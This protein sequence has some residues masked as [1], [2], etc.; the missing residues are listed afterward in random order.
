MN[1]PTHAHAEPV[2][3]PTAAPRQAAPS[4]AAA[5]GWRRALGNSVVAAL[6]EASGPAEQAADAAANRV[7]GTRWAAAAHRPPPPPSPPLVSREAGRPLDDATRARFEAAFAA[8]L[9]GVRLHTDAAAHRAA[10]QLGAAAFAAG[11][12]IAFARGTYAPETLRGAWLLAHEIAH[13]LQHDPSAPELVRC[14][15]EDVPMLDGRLYEG[16]QKNSTE[17][18]RQA[19]EA[20]NAFSE[21]DIRL[22]LSPAPGPGRRVLSRGQIAAIHV[23]AREHPRLGP[24]SNAATFTRPAYLDVNLDN[25][26]TRG[27]WSGAAEYLNA[28]ND[29]DMKARLSTF[30]LD[31]LR[32]LQ[33]GAHQ[34]AK[35]GSGSAAARNVAAAIAEAT[36]ALAT[37]G[38]V[39]LPTSAHGAGPPGSVTTIPVGRDAGG[40]VDVRAADR[41]PLP[42]DRD[43]PT[44]PAFIDRNIVRATYGLYTGLFQIEYA[45]G[46]LLSLD[47][48]QVAAGARAGAPPVPG[49][50]RHRR[51]G[52]IYPTR[53]TRHTVPTI[54]AC[55]ED[56]RRREPEALR[57]A[58]AAWIDLAVSAHGVAGAVIRTGRAQQ[59]TPATRETAPAERS[60]GDG[61]ASAPPP[62]RPASPRGPAPAAGDGVSVAGGATRPTPPQ[63]RPAGKPAPAAAAGRGAQAPRTTGGLQEVPTGGRIVY[64]PTEG[65]DP[66]AFGS[67]RP[68]FGANLR[69]Q[70]DYGQARIDGTTLGRG[71]LIATQATAQAVNNAA[72]AAE[73]PLVVGS[74]NVGHAVL[75]TGGRFVPQAAIQTGRAVSSI[76]VLDNEI[77]MI[78]SSRPAP[79]PPAHAPGAPAPAPAVEPTSP[80]AV[81][82]PG[83]AASPALAPG[84]P[85]DAEVSE[86][87][88]DTAADCERLWLA[89]TRHQHHVFPQEFRAEFDQIG[90]E[91]DGYVISVKAEDH[92][93]AHGRNDWNGEWVDFFSEVPLRSL[94]PAE[95]ERWRERALLLV[96]HQLQ[97]MNWGHLKVRTYYRVVKK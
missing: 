57:L 4:P 80:E 74:T 89:G 95:R 53:L 64:H 56:I 91:V 37:R 17:G 69:H 43:W 59:P 61:A 49:F 24:G 19:A 94:R 86:P 13:V 71:R 78:V 93:R 84:S 3:E 40:G 36:R 55:A 97:R 96:T 35:V 18:Y 20:L 67:P 34:N 22:R 47:L 11:E 52:R 87:I 92:R 50:F 81:R 1:E 76:L 77:Y 83:P 10:E 30:T 6:A 15:P 41:E 60:A 62:P 72:V 90:I 33:L 12:H 65:L 82:A 8:D 16:I 54:T 70:I 32:S 9:S 58:E 63:P 68:S 48:D 5:I 26:I 42:P 44:D 75:L 46:G 38:D 73:G 21:E 27:N 29:P 25:E 45:D 14:A 2:T 79:E 85:T 23:A 39:Q 28:F 7:T 51:T 66:A 88:T 31:R